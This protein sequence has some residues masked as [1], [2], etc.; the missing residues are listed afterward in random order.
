MRLVAKVDAQGHFI[1]D[2]LLEDSEALPVECI[3]TRPP[4]GF[5]TPQWTGSE[6]TEG[7]PAA[8]IL[9]ATREAKEAE[10]RG[11]ADSWY[12]ANVRSFEGAIVTA[13]YGRSGLTALN[14]EE[15]AVFDEMSANYTRLKGLITQVRAAATVEELEG[16]SWT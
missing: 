5:Y 16:I 1:E 2:V 15:R 12:Q 9:V 4:E 3:A 8:E 13:K 14:A 6:W 11:A 10:L 7:K